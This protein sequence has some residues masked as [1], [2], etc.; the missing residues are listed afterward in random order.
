MS[1]LN[2]KNSFSYIKAVVLLAFSIIIIVSFSTY[3]DNTEPT[4]DNFQDGHVYIVLANSI[5]EKNSVK[6]VYSMMNKTA[7]GEGLPLLYASIFKIFGFSYYVVNFINMILLFSAGYLVYRLALLSMPINDSILVALVFLTTSSSFSMMHSYFS[8][9]LYLPLSLG[10][11]LCFVYYFKCKGSHSLLIGGVALMT[12]AILTRTIGYTLLISVLLAG[13]A[14]IVYKNIVARIKVSSSKRLIVLCG[15]LFALIVIGVFSLYVIHTDGSQYFRFFQKMVQ[16]GDLFYQIPKLLND[17]S[18]EIFHYQSATL[19]I[20]VIVAAFAVFLFNFKSLSTIPNTYFLVYVSILILFPGFT[21]RYLWVILPFIII[22]HYLLLIQIFQRISGSIKSSEKMTRFIYVGAILVNLGY[23]V[24]EA[25]EFNTQNVA[26]DIINSFEWIN[27]NNDSK[28]VVHFRSDKFPKAHM[29][30]KMNNLIVKKSGIE[31]KYNPKIQSG[32]YLITTSH[33]D[34]GVRYNIPVRYRSHFDSMARTIELD[35]EY[36][37]VKQIGGS[38]VWM[39]RPQSEIQYEHQE[40]LY[41]GSFEYMSSELADH[42]WKSVNARLVVHGGVLKVSGINGGLAC[43]TKVV[44]NLIINKVYLVSLSAEPIKSQVTVEIG[45]NDN[46]RQY[47]DINYNKPFEDLRFTFRAIE[48]K[49]V[50]RLCGWKKTKPPI[51]LFDNISV[52]EVVSDN[53]NYESS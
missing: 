23:F 4:L 25:K 13:V 22:S 41:G 53:V 7:F 28:V 16:R 35:S 34:L 42:G 24:N 20:I 51:V 32:E 45:V 37:L 48:G 27:E 12:A 5:L 30:H 39:K 43:A 52:R 1:Y 31:K 44:D 11:I 33:A 6:E 18:Y 21:V 19:G 47:A 3:G 9:V 2:L 46:L 14:P 8:E 15:G 38:R 49:V 17:S 50:F 40:L 36:K 10:C 26:K 29:L